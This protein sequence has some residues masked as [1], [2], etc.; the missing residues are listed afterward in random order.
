MVMISVVR[1]HDD[2]QYTYL[3]T[4][5]NIGAK[6]CVISSSCRYTGNRGRIVA[7]S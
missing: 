6:V 3:H 2:S 5:M 1:F 7:Q 4:D